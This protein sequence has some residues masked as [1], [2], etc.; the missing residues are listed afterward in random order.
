MRI[1]QPS[2]SREEPRHRLLVLFKHL[3]L[4]GVA[5]S[6]ECAIELISQDG[7][8]GADVRELF[9]AGVFAE[10]YT[11]QKVAPPCRDQD[12]GQRLIGVVT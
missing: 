3:G 6:W 11:L 7:E 8:P 12:A 10:V 2:P 5:P 9:G 4:A 1:D